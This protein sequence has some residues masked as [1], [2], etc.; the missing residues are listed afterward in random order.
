[1]VVNVGIRRDPSISSK[2]KDIY[3]LPD[4]TIDIPNDIE[5]TYRL[6]LIFDSKV[7]KSSSIQG[8]DFEPEDII[9]EE[10]ECKT[11]FI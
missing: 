10:E 11:W 8:I 2:A 3:P 5:S 6:N 7:R 9:D 1:M 4:F